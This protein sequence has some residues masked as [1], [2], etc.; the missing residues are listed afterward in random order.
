M[1]FLNTSHHIPSITWLVVALTGMIATVLLLRLPAELRVRL[2]PVNSL[3]P[4]F[5]SQSVVVSAD[6]RIFTLFAALNAAGFDQEYEGIPMSPV[7]QQIRAALAGKE[8][9]SLARLRPYFDRITDYHLV[10]WV[11]QRGSAPDFGRAEEGWWVSTRPADFDGLAAALSDFYREAEISNL[12]HLVEPQHGVEIDHWQPLAETSMS[13]LQ[14]Y[15]R[16]A[17]LPFQQL[18]VI[19]NLLDSY[20]SGYGPQIGATAYVVAGPTETDLSVK[21]LIEHE[22]LH[23][24]I[25]PMLDRN[26]HIISPAQRN[27][28][29]A[30][31]S[32]LMPSS[33]GTWSSI[34]E[35]SLIRSIGLRMLND[36]LLR[37]RM[38]N[39][40]EDDGFLLIRPLCQALQEYEQ[41]N[42]PFEEYLPV[43]LETINDVHLP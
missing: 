11:L 37:N 14:A 38:I 40:L 27:R 29:F 10:V 24:V 39:Q 42:R 32:K 34:L 28:L 3:R 31:L 13:N 41:S 18:V 23:S 8:I 7:R 16:I 2:E 33:Y 30:V 26:I 4:D 25:G 15:L 12:W 36:E 5:G 35:E 1:R 17:E 43:L 6:E 9:P 19:P 21:G 20:Y 22:M